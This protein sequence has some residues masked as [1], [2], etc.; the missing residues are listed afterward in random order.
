MSIETD[1]AYVKQ[2]LDRTRK[3]VLIDTLPL[4]V[5]GLLTVVGCALSTWS[6]RLNS[7]WLWVVLMAAAWIYAAWRTWQTLS[8]REVVTLVETGV[9]ALW[10]SVYLAM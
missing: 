9:Y 6:E 3:S 5:W 4:L 2:V 1:L 8:A 7:V 10:F